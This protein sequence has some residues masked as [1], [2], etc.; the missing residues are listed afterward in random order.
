ERTITFNDIDGRNRSNPAHPAVRERHGDA[1]RRRGQNGRAHGGPGAD[2]ASYES[3][4]AGVTASLAAGTAVGDGSDTLTGIEN[5]TGS[6]KPDTLN[7]D[8]NANVLDG[9][10]SDDTITGAGGDDV[11]IGGGGSDPLSGGAGV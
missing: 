3:A 9:G 1:P 5:L 7:G 6:A 8:D 2:T 11:L 4:P 10:A